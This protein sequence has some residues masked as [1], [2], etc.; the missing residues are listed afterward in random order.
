MKSH[1]T[2]KPVFIIAASIALVAGV[3]LGITTESKKHV[4]P[5]QIAGTLLTVLGTTV[6]TNGANFFNV[7]GQALT[8]AA[9]LAA[10]QP[11]DMVRAE[12]V[13]AAGALAAVTVRRVP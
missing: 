5:P 7:Q 10:L 12:G 1:H 13:Y 2:F 4:T 11:G 3:W 9:F 8:Q 6:N